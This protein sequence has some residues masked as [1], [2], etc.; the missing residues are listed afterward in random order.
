VSLTA[1]SLGLADHRE[2]GLLCQYSFE[3]GAHYRVV[4]GDQEPDR[5]AHP[6]SLYGGRAFGCYQGQLDDQR[7]TFFRFALYE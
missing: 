1:S 4:V 6:T 5:S 7:A 2:V 3:A